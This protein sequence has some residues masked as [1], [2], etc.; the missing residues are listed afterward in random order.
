MTVTAA[1]ILAFEDRRYD[2][3]VAADAAALD[4]LLADSLLYT[5]SNGAVDTKASFID[6]L[7]SGRLKYRAVRRLEADVK[8][9]EHA[10]IVGAH[11]NLDVTVGGTD[12]TINVRA[13]IT[14]VQTASGWKFAAWQSTPLP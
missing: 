5:H 13:T 12:R 11:V 1:E 8:T 7:T 2:A 6:A 4:E 14:W 10:A 9:Y 3:M